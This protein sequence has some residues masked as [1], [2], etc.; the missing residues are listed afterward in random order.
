MIPRSNLASA[1]AALLDALEAD[2]LGASPEE[3]H[4]ALR[5]TGRARESAV[6]EI[7]SLLRDTEA[8]GHNRCPLALP[9]DESDGMGTQRH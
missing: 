2:L 5:E 9:S 6:G 3:V 7:R 1:L 4:A 8:E